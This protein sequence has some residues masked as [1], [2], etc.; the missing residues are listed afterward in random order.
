[1]LWTRVNSVQY[2]TRLERFVRGD[3]PMVC[4]Y[5]GRPADKLVPLQAYR[6]S[7]WPWLFFPSLIFAVAKW[8]GDSD[9]PWGLLPFANGQ[10]RGIT[11]TYEKGIGVILE[12]V[13]PVFVEQVKKSQGRQGLADS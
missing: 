11:A 10:V 13:H 9:H 8:I 6:S 7:L 5:S 4:A 3:F 12:G 2:V 1:M